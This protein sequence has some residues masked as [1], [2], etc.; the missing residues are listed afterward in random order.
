MGKA[1]IVSVTILIIFLTVTVV[2]YRAQARSKTVG[3]LNQKQERELRR[4]LSEASHVMRGIGV[5]VHIDDSDVVSDRSRR[6]IENWL[7]RYEDY[8]QKEINA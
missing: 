8:Q 1:I 5:G 2:L 3:D 6:A 7:V 4:L